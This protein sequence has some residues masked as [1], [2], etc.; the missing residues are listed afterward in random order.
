VP[1]QLR[2]AGY[3]Y[4]NELGWYWLGT[5]AYDPVL[6]RFLQPDLSQ[7]TG[8]FSYVY[9]NDDPLDNTDP[10]GELPWCS[11]GSW[12]DGEYCGG[13]PPMAQMIA[14]FNQN[15]P[16]GGSASPLGDPGATIAVGGAAGVAVVAGVLTAQGTIVATGSGVVQSVAGGAFAAAGTSQ[17][18]LDAIAL[19]QAGMGP[20]PVMS[21]NQVASTINSTYYKGL[22]AINNAGGGYVLEAQVAAQIYGIDPNAIIQMGVNFGAAGGYGAGETDIATSQYRFS[23]FGGTN[24]YDKLA[25]LAKE[26]GNPYAGGYTD[27]YGLVHSYMRPLYFV[28]PSIGEDGE[29]LIY[30][31]FDGAVQVIR[32]PQQLASL[33]RL[34]Y[35]ST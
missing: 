30:S 4:D 9:A 13:A 19:A 16:S 12:L 11:H 17:A 7:S 15:P 31:A 21:P 22:Q 27:Q 18:G 8:L 34:G 6:E 3:W 33:M 26:L 24:A 29:R 32:N 2:Y 14:E 28:A 35:M 5:R 1:Q 10:T 25:Q 23:V 20:S